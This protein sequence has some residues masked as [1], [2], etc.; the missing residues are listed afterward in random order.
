MNLKEYLNQTE[1]KRAT[2]VEL[3]T[4]DFNVEVCFG[5]GV[6]RRVTIIIPDLQDEHCSGEYCQKGFERFLYA[7]DEDGNPTG[8]S[9]FYLP[10]DFYIPKNTSDNINAE[11]IIQLDKYKKK[12]FGLGFSCMDGKAYEW[13]LYRMNIGQ[14][15]ELD[16]KIIVGEVIISGKGDTDEYLLNS[17]LFTQDAR[18][19]LNDVLEAEESFAEIDGLLIVDKGFFH[20]QICDVNMEEHLK[21]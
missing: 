10:K 2:K 8:R 9:V 11:Q 17:P 1:M 18:E 19:V 21:D 13:Y 6:D 4:G 3:E 20:L 5:K 14:Y 12:L 7:T 15:N 16:V